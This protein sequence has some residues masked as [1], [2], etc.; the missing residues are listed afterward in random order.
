VGGRGS[1]AKNVAKVHRAGALS[2]LVVIVGTG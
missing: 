1:R 2:V